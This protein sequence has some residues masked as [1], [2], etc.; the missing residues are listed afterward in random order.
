[1]Q[2]CRHTLVHE[3]FAS[4]DYLGS[5]VLARVSEHSRIAVLARVPV[6]LLVLLIALPCIPQH[7]IT[8]LQC[9]SLGQAFFDAAPTETEH[10]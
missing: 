3:W 7:V 10:D 6:K 1:M 9:I 2:A 5:A 8:L 4:R